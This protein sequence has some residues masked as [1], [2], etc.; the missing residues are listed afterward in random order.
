MI[1]PSLMLELNAFTWLSA[2]RSRTG[3]K[4]TLASVPDSEW[5]T[6]RDRGFDAVWLMGVWKRSPRAK[7]SALKHAGLK[8]EYARALPGW[9]ADDVAGSAY[10][11][12]DYVLDPFLGPPKD[13]AAVRSKLNKLGLKLFV[14]FVPNHVACDHRWTLKS[15]DRFVRPTP[16]ARRAHPER[17]FKPAGGVYLAHGRD[18]HFVPWTDTAQIN[19]FSPDARAAMRRTLET[20]A[21][22][23]DGVRC[24]MAMLLLSDIFKKTWGDCVS[25]PPKAEFW[26]DVLAPV[27]RQFP[28]FTVIAE[29]YWGTGARLLALGF[30][31]V[32]DKTLYDRFVEGDPEVIREYLRAAP[33]DQRPNLRFAENHDEP[34]MV[35]K[36]GRD[37]ALAVQAATLTVPGLR[38]F[39]QDQEKGFLN[40]VPV[41]LKRFAAEAEDAVVFRATGR[42]LNF[43]RLP[44]PAGGRWHLLEPQPA[45]PGSAAHRN[46]LAWIW[47]RGEDFALVAVNYGSERGSARL[48][49]PASCGGGIRQLRDWA[50]DA[51]YERQGA[52]MTGEGLYVDLAPWKYHLFAPPRSPISA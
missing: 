47:T 1:L 25:A 22:V 5:R 24:D 29:T 13:L 20:I 12:A 19:A 11:V 14:D 46:I 15:F 16:S 6:L 36:F 26:S 45:W 28:D 4:L 2:L 23:A 42:L 17:F 7:Q 51:V 44:A 48:R 49:L 18:P 9:I 21:G 34:R 50:D 52:E 8:A 40:R 41:Q 27:K 3:K 43:L 31:A 30:D 33:E 39:H 32:Y 35:A 38:L 10:A 37:R